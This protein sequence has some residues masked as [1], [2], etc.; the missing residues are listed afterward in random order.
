MEGSS[1]FVQ[2]DLTKWM[3]LSTLHILCPVIFHGPSGTAQV[4]HYPVAKKK[5]KEDI[6]SILRL[7]IKLQS[8]K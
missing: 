7:I 6:S 5:Q 1:V 4:H 8:V 3:V 2:D